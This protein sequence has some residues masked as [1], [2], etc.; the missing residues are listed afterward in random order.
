MSTLGAPRSGPAFLA[1][2]AV[3]FIASAPALA[4]DAPTA[5]GGQDRPAERDE[6]I[7][8]GTAEA[9]PPE[10]ES[11]KA[12]SDILD[13]PQTITVIS[14]QTLRKQNLQTLRDALQKKLHCL[15]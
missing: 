14:D 13:T 15:Q 1:L 5:G 9:R 2:A 10:V 8:T 12:T 7:V 3:G 11:P 6:I 4:A